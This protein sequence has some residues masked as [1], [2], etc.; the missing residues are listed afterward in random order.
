MKR[1]VWFKIRYKYMEGMVREYNTGEQKSI[2]SFGFVLVLNTE[3][4][5]GISFDS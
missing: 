3:L 2:W 1:S 4:G 5:F